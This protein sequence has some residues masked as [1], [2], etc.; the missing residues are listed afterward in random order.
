MGSLD[1]SLNW[2]GEG[3]RE[4]LKVSVRKTKENSFGGLWRAGLR[5]EGEVEWIHQLTDDR[6][7]HSDRKDGQIL[8]GKAHTHLTEVH[9]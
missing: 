9:A 1:F 5:S 7:F 2:G 3:K 8:I 6:G 4:I